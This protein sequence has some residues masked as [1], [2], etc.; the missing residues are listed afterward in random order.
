[1]RHAIRFKFVINPAVYHNSNL[2]QNFFEKSLE[3]F[4]ACFHRIHDTVGRVSVIFPDDN[5]FRFISKL[6]KKRTAENRR[7]YQD[8]CRILIVMDKAEAYNSKDTANQ[9]CDFGAVL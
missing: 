5:F 8:S 2:F 4:E 6:N 9:E 1:V 7:E 3:I